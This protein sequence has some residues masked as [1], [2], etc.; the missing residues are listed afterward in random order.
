MRNDDTH[1]H[2]YGDMMRFFGRHAQIKA[3][4]TDFQGA[5]PDISPSDSESLAESN[6]NQKHA[7]ISIVKT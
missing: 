1:G 3:K 4:D 5:R 7:A 2:V 6:T